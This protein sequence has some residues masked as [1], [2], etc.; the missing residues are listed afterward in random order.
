MS[1]RHEVSR[2]GA[3]KDEEIGMEKLDTPSRDIPIAIIGGGMAGLSCAQRL[4][5]LGHECLVIDRGRR[6][7]GRMS[8]KRIAHEREQLW[9]DQGAPKID[10]H[11][12]T[13]REH[14]EKWVRE[15]KARWLTRTE[16][17]GEPSM[18]A[19]LSA[20]SL[21]CDALSSA[22]VYSIR[23]DG[24]L[25]VLTVQLYGEETPFVISADHVVIATPAEQSVRILEQSGLIVPE[26]LR[27][28]QSSTAWMLLLGL[29]DIDLEQDWIDIQGT[30]DDPLQ[31][32]RLRRQSGGSYAIVA[33]MKP[34]ISASLM[35]EDRQVIQELMLS[36]CMTALNHRFGTSIASSQ[37]S[38]PRVHRWG[39]ARPLTQV[40][41]PFLISSELDLRFVGDWLSGPRGEWHNAE[42]AFLSGL[43]LADH[44][45]NTR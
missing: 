29:S 10:V 13:L 37:C 28:I 9:I 5:E 30:D 39:L 21:G 7:G 8:S 41:A 43:S 3:A 18:S 45:S 44:I 24:D 14:A 31:E 1:M 26:A 32:I 27:A 15:G 12:D 2:L 19:I 38:E 23:R 42:A 16:L 4:N 11:S 40:Q 20:M 36:S 17:I 6:I 25:F 34:Q 35:A 22:E 33:E